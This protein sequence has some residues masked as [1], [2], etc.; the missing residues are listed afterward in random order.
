MKSNQKENFGLDTQHLLI[1]YMLS[2]HDAFLQANSIIKPE[3]FSDTLIKVVS[4]I[5]EYSE[6]THTLPMVEQIYAETKYKIEK[7]SET[8]LQHTEKWFL[9]TIESFCRYKAIEDCIL[10]GLDYIDTGRAGELERRI[11][12]AVS[13][14]LTR[15]LGTDY[16]YDPYTRLEAMKDKSG[17]ISTGWLS[18][19]KKITGFVQGALNIFCAGSGVGKS[20][21]L[22]NLAINWA[23]A[24]MDVIYFS[25]ELDE[26]LV[27]N[28][29]D[30]MITDMSNGEIFSNIEHAALKIKAIGKRING[31]ITVKKLPEAGTTSNILRAYLKEYEIKTG[32]RPD[33]IIV[34]YLDLMYPNNT[35]IDPSDLF[36][37]DKFT[38]EEMRA[39]AGEYN[40]LLATASQ[41][42][43]N[44]VSQTEYDPSH[45]AGGISK[46]STA[47]NLF[48]IFSTMSMK[49][50]GKMNLQLLKTR[51]SSAVG[52]TLELKYNPKTLRITDADSFTGTTTLLTKEEINKQIKEPW[53]NKPTPEQTLNGVNKL[54]NKIKARNI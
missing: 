31:S 28:R 29:L 15:D 14:S 19:D 53:E 8:S 23:F 1:Q 30:M 7:T 44:A 46:L 25:L 42:N 21:F 33:V 13:I 20:L 5:K 11:K 17:Y 16:F 12:D 32:K 40:V 43:R 36:V 35:K 50:Q 41:L 22:Q 2:D 10:T 3:Y 37:K 9:P 45:I 51:S 54:L 52:Q 39:L 38:S 49:E 24:N 47:D 4:Y 18:L 34:D 6:Q 48:A 27:S 26:N